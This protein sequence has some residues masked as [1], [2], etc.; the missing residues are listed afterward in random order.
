MVDLKDLLKAGVHFGH[1]T[2]RWS[3]KM[4]PFIWGS[5]NKIHLIDIAKTAFLMERAGKYLQNCAAE[6]KSILFVGT[7]KSAQKA[8]ATIA[9]EINS[10]FVINR[11]VGGTLTNFDQ[12]K[13]AITRLLHLQDIIKKPTDYYKK[14]ELSLIQKEVE[15]LE[16]N[17]GG[18]LDLRFPPAALVLV[19]AKKE[20]SALREA[21]NAKI[22]VI[23]LVDT[24]TN[25]DGINFVIPAND[26]S[27]RS[28][29][30][31]LQY[32]AEFVK[33]G[34]KLHNEKKTAA[35]V[36][37]KDLIQK[38][39]TAAQE[40]LTSNTP[41]VV[42]YSAIEAEDEDLGGDKAIAKKITQKI[43]SVAKDVPIKKPVARRPLKK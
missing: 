1:K 18:I 40:T 28:I 33:N 36:D 14:K 41:E 15:R 4:K 3:P 20:L 16:K 5:K 8:I 29:E 23:A 37:K 2:S 9:K 31:I 6:G 21:V 24:N 13:K 43:P 35:K 38:A 25:P 26:D 39:K 17:I 12:V 32:L 42:D 27:S 7:K 10:P 22:P 30:F 34:Q 11:W 19:D